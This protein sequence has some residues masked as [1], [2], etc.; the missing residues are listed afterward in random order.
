MCPL[1]GPPIMIIKMRYNA[2]SLNNVITPYEDV[3]KV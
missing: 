3:I 2:R 1:A